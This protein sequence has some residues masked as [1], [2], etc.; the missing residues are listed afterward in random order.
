MATISTTV[1]SDF[2]V[3]L[4]GDFRVHVIGGSIRLFAKEGSAYAIYGD[5][6]DVGLRLNSGS[7]IATSP[8]ASMVYKW[9]VLTGSPAVV[10]R[11]A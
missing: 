8:E 3:P 5:I 6:P 9:Q 4:A 10:V 2:T 1:D 7:A 11:Q